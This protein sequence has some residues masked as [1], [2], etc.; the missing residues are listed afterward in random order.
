M[1]GKRL[2]RS[3]FWV[4]NVASL[5]IP[6]PDSVEVNLRI[7]LLGKWNDA[8]STYALASCESLRFWSSRLE[9]FKLRQFLSLS[10]KDANLRKN[11]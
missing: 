8:C 3:Q 9:I 7:F 10:E 4:I 1:I 11:V 2:K 5:K 6:N